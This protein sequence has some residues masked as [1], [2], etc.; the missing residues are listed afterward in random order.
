MRGNASLYKSFEGGSTFILFISGVFSYS[1]QSTKS[2]YRGPESVVQCILW[3][4]LWLRI[5]TD[6]DKK[7]TY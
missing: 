2:K 3:L 5:F 1:T 7:L 6:R 4:V